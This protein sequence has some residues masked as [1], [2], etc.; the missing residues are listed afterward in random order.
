MKKSFSSAA[1]AFSKMGGPL[2]KATFVSQIIFLT[3]FCPAVPAA[4]HGVRGFLGPVPGKGGRGCRG[5]KDDD[6]GRGGSLEDAEEDGVCEAAAEAMALAANGKVATTVPAD[7]LPADFLTIGRT[8]GRPSL[9]LPTARPG[10]FEGSGGTERREGFDAG[11][12]TA[13]EGDDE[14]L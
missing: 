8:T 13:C 14:L 5:G 1:A 7:A 3:R 12:G 4:A 9:R 6:E 10:D 11:R 2:K